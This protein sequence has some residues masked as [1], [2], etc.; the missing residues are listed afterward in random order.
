MTVKDFQ[1]KTTADLEKDLK[2]KRSSIRDMRFGAAGAKNK[3]T[4]LAVKTR[5]DV[6]RI[7]TELRNR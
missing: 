4:G 7:L 5:R 6:A 2:E 1:K 3:D